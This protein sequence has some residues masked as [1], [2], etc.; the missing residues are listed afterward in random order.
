ML[1]G[2]RN[3]EIAENERDN[4]DIVEAQAVFDQVA[5]EELR[6]G[7]F[8]PEHVDA[9]SENQRQRDIKRR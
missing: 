4:E 5:G 8:A 2:G 9:G 7:L 3:C 1:V 6:P